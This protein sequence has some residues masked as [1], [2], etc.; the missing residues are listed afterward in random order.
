MKTVCEP[1]NALE[2]QMLL[3]LLQQR[4]IHARLDGAGLQGAVG[5]LPAFGLVRLRVE[6]E[7]FVAARTVID[8]WEKTTVPDPIRIPPKRLPGALVGAMVG[9]ILGFGAAYIYFRVPTNA[10]GIDYNGDGVLDERWIYSPSGMAI[11]TELDRN[12]DKMVDLR[13]HFDRYGHTDTGES[14]DDFDGTFESAMRYRNGLVYVT[15]VDTNGDSFSDMRFLFQHGVPTQG[16]YINKDSDKPLRIDSY[17][18]GKLVSADVDTDRDGTLDRR[19]LYD[20]LGNIAS[21][22]DIDTPQ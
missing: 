6:E 20:G 13:W 8:E 21:E 11:S 19:Y 3:D 14:D 9:L 2:G 15:A 22:E 4:G 7:D 16:E 18:F 10:D 12:L 5:E 1:S 17:R